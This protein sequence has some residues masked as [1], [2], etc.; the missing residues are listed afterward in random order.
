MLEV[1]SE[2]SFPYKKLTQREIVFVLTFCVCT[3]L[4]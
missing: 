4:S 3:K 2:Y 1:R